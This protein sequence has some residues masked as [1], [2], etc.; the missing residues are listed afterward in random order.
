[1]Q[2]EYWNK[3]I[4]RA[5][6]ETLSDFGFGGARSMIIT[7][8]LAAVAAVLI[9]FWSGYDAFVGELISKAALIAGLILLVPVLFF[10]RVL[11]LPA[12]LDEEARSNIDDLLRA[13]SVLDGS[14]SVIEEFGRLH[15]KASDLIE[16]YMGGDE[17]EEVN[18]LMNQIEQK[19][20]DLDAR[21]R[22]IVLAD[23]LAKYDHK[24][25]SGIVWDDDEFPPMSLLALRVQAIEKAFGF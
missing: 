12:K 16:E 2:R 24:R 17:P 19:A 4:T 23:S 21:K 14:E 25:W 7:A 11:S 3:I 18:V 22:A 10:I 1:M 15:K 6:C 8:A 20:N 5:W 13:Q 9:G